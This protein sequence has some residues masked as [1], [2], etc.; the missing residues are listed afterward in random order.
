[1]ARLLKVLGLG[2]L[3]CCLGA[4]AQQS[5]MLA[6]DH[7]LQPNDLAWNVERCINAKHGCAMAPIATLDRLS[8]TYTDVDVH[9]QSAYCYRV[10]A[11]ASPASNIVCTP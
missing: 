8:T 1:M 5:H 4:R 7:V 9:P 2:L 10:K 3:L 6:W 11:T